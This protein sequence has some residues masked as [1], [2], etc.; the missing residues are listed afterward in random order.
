MENLYACDIN[1]FYLY[2]ADSWKEDILV[3]KSETSGKIRLVK[4]STI[5]ISLVPENR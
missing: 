5:L 4:H 1:L 3:T 2:F